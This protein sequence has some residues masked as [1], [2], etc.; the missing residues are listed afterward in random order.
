VFQDPW[1]AAFINS[2]RKEENKIERISRLKDGNYSIFVKIVGKKHYME[3]DGIP[4]EMLR[5]LRTTRDCAFYFYLGFV[6]RK[7]F[8]LTLV[9]DQII[10]QLLESGIIQYWL[11]RMFETKYPLTTFSRVY[12]YKTPPDEIE[13]TA[14]RV[15][16]LQGAFF[17]LI[18]GMQIAFIAFIGEILSKR[19]TQ[20]RT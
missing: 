2:Y 14:L 20:K 4:I 15:Q 12:E 17:I 16:N 8:P 7:A 18:I 11:D 3:V 19:I 10:R 9:T 5:D 1:H 13:L 6:N